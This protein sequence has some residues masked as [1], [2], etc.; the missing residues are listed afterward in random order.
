VVAAGELEG[1]RDWVEGDVSGSPL[2]RE[3]RRVNA[4]EP[5]PA[6]SLNEDP[7]SDP[8]ASTAA[9]DA[10]AASKLSKLTRRA[11][12]NALASGIDFGARMVVEFVLNPI[13]LRGLGSLLFGTWRVLWRLTGYLWA[14]TGRSAQTLQSALANRLHSEDVGEKQRFVG[15][16]VIAWIAFLPVLVVATALATWLLPPV[17][18]IPTDDVWAVR[19]AIV[20]LGADAIALSLLTLPRSVLQGENLGYKR[21]GLSTA[22]VVLNGVITAAAIWF[23]LGIVGVAGANLLQTV[24]TGALFWRIT[25]R[26]VPWFGLA[27]PSRPEVRWFL[28]LSTWFTVWKFVNQLMVAGD[29]LV[30]GAFAS[31]EE[32]TVYSLSKFI[33]EA[34]LPLIALMVMGGI[35]GL[36]GI[37]GGGNLGRARRVRGDV[38][39]MTWLVAVVAA[40]A[41]LV[42]NR[43]FVTLWVGE[44][45]YAGDVQMLLIM[46]ALVQLGMIRNDAFIIDLTLNVRAKVL[47]GL[48]SS[49]VA[50]GLAAV[51]IRAYDAGI[52]ALCV[53]LILG[54]AILTIAYPWLVGR[55]IDDPLRQQVRAAVRPLVATAALFTVAFLVGREVSVGSWLLLVGGSVATALVATTFAALAGLTAAQRVSLVK[56]GRAIVGR[57]SS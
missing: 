54:R 42:W 34:V 44:R 13:L 29:V 24:Y 7:S 28:G 35:P 55:A 47:V 1:D 15:A 27:R 38:M 50:L 10:N 40:A 46:V 51:L 52:G 41:I 16:A 32:V 19:W 17:L 48:A 11:S 57:S 39:A 9:L 37:I 30:L 23:G 49:L 20:L 14:T 22:L 43:T 26:H 21:L 56:R 36:G 33:P 53:G 4:A 18:N 31:V 45:Y 25:R 5:T 6:V 8:S 2:A 3:G 12:F